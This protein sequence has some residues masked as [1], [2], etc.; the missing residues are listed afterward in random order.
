MRYEDVIIF[1]PF[2]SHSVPT[3]NYFYTNSQDILAVLN[4]A[5]SQV[6]IRKDF[7]LQFSQECDFLFMQSAAQ[8]KLAYEDTITGY[9]SDTVLNAFPLCYADF[10]LRTIEG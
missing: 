9:T 6:R 3:G 4:T 5:G 2:K 8:I 10:E 7:Q 1:Q